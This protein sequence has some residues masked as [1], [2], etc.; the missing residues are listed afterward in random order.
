MWY[1][2]CALVGIALGY[3]YRDLREQINSL[4]KKLPSPEIGV[5]AGSYGKQRVSD[6]SKDVGL[7]EA[8]TPEQIEWE[9][10][11]KLSESLAGK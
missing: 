4:K 9:N 7:V 2:L 5:T 10:R 11:K 3:L 1:I 8:K 6:P